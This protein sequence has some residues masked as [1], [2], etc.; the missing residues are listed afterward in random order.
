MYMMFVAPSGFKTRWVLYDVPAH[1]VSK[2]DGHMN[3][4]SYVLI[5]FSDHMLGVTCVIDYHDH[6][7]STADAL[8]LRTNKLKLSGNIRS[9]IYLSCRTCVHITCS[10]FQIQPC[11]V[12]QR[13]CFTMVHA[14]FRW[15]STMEYMMSHEYYDSSQV[16]DPAWRPD[17]DDDF[18]D[19]LE[20]DLSD[21][22]W[23]STDAS[24][25]PVHHDTSLDAAL[26]R[27][28]GPMPVESDVNTSDLDRWFGT[29]SV[30]S[31]IDVPDSP[32]P[33]IVDSGDNCLPAP[34]GTGD[35][36]DIADSSVSTVCWEAM[37]VPATPSPIVSHMS[38]PDVIV[39]LDLTDTDEPEQKRF[40]E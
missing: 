16:L 30:G 33:V 23:D 22:N 13:S 37:D 4:V 35:N 32:T 29:M 1:L 28:F 7:V 20:T 21:A 10:Y 40:R 26:D 2:P 8:C 31:V 3:D 15:E 18:L 38:S 39:Y 27:L 9:Y 5:L 17:S 12:A 11:S 25:T 24:P 19:S 34:V 36:A 6:L 14:P